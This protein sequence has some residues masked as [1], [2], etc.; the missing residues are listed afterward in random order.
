[1][2]VENGGSVNTPN[3]EEYFYQNPI[4][5]ADYSDPDV[6]RDGDD[7]YMVASSFTYLPGVPLLHSR[8]L[9]HWELINY[10]VEQLPF[11]RYDQPAHGCGC[12]AP[13]I[14][15]HGEIFYV[16]IP[17]PDEGIFVATAKDPY[18]KWSLHCLKESYGCIDPCPFWDEDGKTYMVFAYAKSRCGIK[19]R[20]SIC[21]ISSDA[22]KILSEPVTV[23][24]G[25][26]RNPT[27]EGPKLYKRNGYYYIFAPA[28]GV[29][30]GWQTV[31]RSQNIYGPYESKIVM[32][33]G[34]TKI[35]G[36]HQGGYV[37][38]GN[39][40]GA[41]IH[42]QDRGP[43]GRIIH[44]QPLDWKDDWPFIGVEQNGDG[45]GE[46]VEVWNYLI[47]SKNGIDFKIPTDD[48]FDGVNLG[49]Q[50][51][52]Q[53]NPKKEWYDIGKKKSCL[54]LYSRNNPVREENLLWYAPNALTQIPQQAEFQATVKVELHA[55]TEGDQV[56]F[57][58][59]GQ[60]YTYLALCRNKGENT[61]VL[62]EGIVTENVGAG[63]ADEKMLKQ[64]PW[65]SDVLW[66]RIM[67]QDG[68]IYGYAYSENG[69]DY[70]KI[71]GGEKFQASPCTWTGMKL[72]LAAWNIKNRTSTGWADI[73]F[74]RFE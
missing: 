11:S 30:Q 24:D 42:F 32:H 14:R 72:V 44:L 66:I 51:Q 13:S 29:P 37:D 15:K 52:W 10:C 56:A 45:I 60:R 62:R 67:M 23:Y 73:D 58:I 48:E 16:F 33:Q 5:H 31:L 43:Y 4:L 71:D 74:I 9:V 7:F 2:A 3:G 6:I 27:I 49:I 25:T 63:K 47:Q 41:F 18:G 20:L 54:R 12:W 36:P 50:W 69:K 68:A 70:C 57:G 55:E 17:L 40:S 28:G 38:L 35:N 19:H 8:D 65:N 53:A 22:T 21:E 39:E 59:L 1:M 64:L 34:N 61:L 26:L 46:P